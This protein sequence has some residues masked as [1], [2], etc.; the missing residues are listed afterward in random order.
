MYDSCT[1]NI[2]VYKPHVVW[3]PYRNI[4]GPFYA[5]E[6]DQGEALGKEGE[7]TRKI[8]CIRSRHWFHNDDQEIFLME[9][10]QLVSQASES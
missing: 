6:E 5:S 1:R 3:Q 2:Q 4:D 7:H 9:Y 8:S 10:F